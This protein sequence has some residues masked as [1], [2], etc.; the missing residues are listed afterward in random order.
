MSFYNISMN[1]EKFFSVFPSGDYRVTF[2]ISDDI[3]DKILRLTFYMSVKSPDKHSFWSKIDLSDPMK[4]LKSL[5]AIWYQ[6]LYSQFHSRFQR[7]LDESKSADK[8]QNGIRDRCVTKIKSPKR[9]IKN[10]STPNRS[11][12]KISNTMSVRRHFQ[13]NKS[14]FRSSN[15]LVIYVVT[16]CFFSECLLHNNL[17]KRKLEIAQ[18]R[19]FLKRSWQ[20]LRWRKVQWR[21][22]CINLQF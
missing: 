16:E 14:L 21:Y 11:V 18:R 4:R 3:D 19:S 22:H 5:K 9:E 13:S 12:I 15:I 10:V 7:L 20:T 8:E 17:L 6:S 1:S 2:H